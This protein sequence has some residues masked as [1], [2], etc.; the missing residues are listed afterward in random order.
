MF[1]RTRQMWVSPPPSPANPG[2]Q[3]NFYCYSF[4]LH[5]CSQQS[6]QRVWYGAIRRSLTV[7][8]YLYPR[9]QNILNWMVKNQFTCSLSFHIN[10]KI[11]YT[12][13]LMRIRWRY[14]SSF[15]Q[16]NY[17]ILFTCACFVHKAEAW[18]LR[19]SILSAVVHFK[20]FP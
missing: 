10:H 7:K 1:S 4:T 2:V 9:I 17:K 16:K 14:T 20:H 11:T 19:R 3:T 18:Q 13:S 12:Q 5:Y 8:V 15:S 6:A